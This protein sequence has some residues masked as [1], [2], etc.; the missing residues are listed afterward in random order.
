MDPNAT[1]ERL[2]RAI[3]DHNRDD[4]AD[5]ATDLS[6]WLA[7]GGFA[8]DWEAAIWGLYERMP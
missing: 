2:L 4:A 3:L 5:A 6:E 1:V 7:K 8:P